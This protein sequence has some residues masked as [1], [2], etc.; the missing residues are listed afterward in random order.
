MR[1]HSSWRKTGR[2]TPSNSSS[3]SSCI[4]VTKVLRISIASSAYFSTWASVSG[5][6]NSRRSA[7]AAFISRW[8][9]C[10]RPERPSAWLIPSAHR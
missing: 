8:A 9:R 10:R 1:I 6:R 5:K 7:I 2:R 3:L 4:L